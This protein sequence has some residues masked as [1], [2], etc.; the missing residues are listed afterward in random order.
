MSEEKRELVLKYNVGERSINSQR[1]TFVCTGSAARNKG[2]QRRF[3]LYTALVRLHPDTASRLLPQ[4]T[5]AG[6]L[7]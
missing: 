4:K 3:I 5:D 7:G 6:P 1:F 2:K